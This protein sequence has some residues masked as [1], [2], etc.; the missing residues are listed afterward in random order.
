MITDLDVDGVT[1]FIES[2]PNK[3]IVATNGCF[4]ILH[5]GHVAYLEAAKEQG[6]ILIVGLNDDESV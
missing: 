2:H 6:D 3:T 5:A 1:P 4:D